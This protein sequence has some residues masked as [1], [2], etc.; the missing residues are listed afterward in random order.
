MAISIVKEKSSFYFYRI[1]LRFASLPTLRG[2]I[3]EDV[4]VTTRKN[5]DKIYSKEIIE[6]LFPLVAREM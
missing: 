1:I 3:A 5:S 4:I 2:C 6:C